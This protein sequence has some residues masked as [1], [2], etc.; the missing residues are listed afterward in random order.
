M[1]QRNTLL[2]GAAFGCV[3]VLVGAFGAHALKETLSATGRIDTYELAVKYQFYHALALLLT[4]LLMGQSGSR[5]LRYSSISF[6]L[7]ILFFSGS[8]YILSL[9]GQKILGAITP[10]GGLAFILGWG[11]LIIGVTKK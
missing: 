7:G 9:T 2:W 5:F 11:F 10:I 1:N 3:A 6:L 4:G 8:L